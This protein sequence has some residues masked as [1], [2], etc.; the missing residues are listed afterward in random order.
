MNKR[1][2]SI[3]CCVALLF[4]CVAGLGMF[5][6]ADDTY[7]TGATVTTLNSYADADKL[8]TEESLLSADNI[9]AGGSGFNG[10][11]QANLFDGGFQ[12]VNQEVHHVKLAEGATADEYDIN[13]WDANKWGVLTDVEDTRAVLYTKEATTTTSLG[14]A[15]IGFDLGK[16]MTVDKFA[17]GSNAESANNST[18]QAIFAVDS[19][20]DGVVQNFT[21]TTRLH[22]I[23]VYFSNDADTLYDDA[24]KKVAIDYLGGNIAASMANTPLAGIYALDEVVDAQYMGFRFYVAGDGDNNK[25][26]WNGNS[27]AWGWWSQVRLSELAAYGQPATVP[28]T[29]TETAISD[30]DTFN[31]S[32]IQGSKNVLANAAVST[33]LSTSSA[34]PE[35]LTDGVVANITADYDDKSNCTVY[36]SGSSEDTAYGYFTYDFG[37]DYELTSFMLAGSGVS[38]YGTEGFDLYFGKAYGDLTALDKPRYSHE[39]NVT[40]ALKVDFDE[41]VTTQYVT[42]KVYTKKNASSYQ[43]W[44]SE[45]AATGKRVAD[46]ITVTREAVTD[47]A[48]IPG[49]SLIAGKI[50]TTA[51]GDACSYSEKHPEQ[52][53]DGYMQGLN[54]DIHMHLTQ[55]EL[56][57]DYQGKT[58]YSFIAPQSMVEAQGLDTT[59][60][61][62]LKPNNGRWQAS[63][64]SD[65]RAV[66]HSTTAKPVYDL[67]E[68]AF[69]EQILLASST[70]PGTVTNQAGFTIGEAY[71]A[72]R[73]PVMTEQQA[74][75]FKTYAM[76]QRLLW[77]AKV[78]IGST[79]DVFNE[80]ELVFEYDLSANPA[81]ALRNLW[82]LSKAVK[83]RYIGFDFTDC[84][85][86]EGNN[87]VRVS[88]IGVY[89]SKGTAATVVNN[90]NAG[91]V[92]QPA[93]NL[94][95][96]SSITTTL[97]DMGKAQLFDGKLGVSSDG[98][99]M[100]CPSAGSNHGEFWITYDLG[101]KYT[102]DS[103]FIA[104]AM[105][106]SWGGTGLGVYGMDI[107]LSDKSHTT[108]KADPTAYTPVYSTD[109]YITEG[110]LVQFANA[111]ASRYV[112]VR[113]YGHPSDGGNKGQIWLSETGATGTPVSATKTETVK[114]VC[115]GDSITH[116]ST[117]PY[118]GVAGQEWNTVQEPNNYPVQLA[119]LLNA[120]D[121]K[122]NYKVINAGIG[123][124]AAIGTDQIVPDTSDKFTGSN[125][126]NTAPTTWLTEQTSKGYVQEADVVFIML[127]TNDCANA[128]GN[129]TA[130]KPYYQEFYKKVIDAFRAKN[131]NVEIYVLTSPYADASNHAANLVE[132]AQ[133]QKQ[134]AAEWGLPCIDVY[135]ATKAF[136]EENGYE[137]YIHFGDITNGLRI[138]PGEKGLGA[139][140]QAVFDAYY[141]GEE[142]AMYTMNA[143]G[144]QLRG[145]EGGVPSG[146]LAVRFGV[147]APVAG[148][149][150]DEKYNTVLDNSKITI[151]DKQYTVTGMGAVVGIKDKID[152]VNTDLVIGT[153][154]GYLKDVP[155]RYL[156]DC[157]ADT[158]T[159]TAVITNVNEANYNRDLVA[160]GYVKYM[161]GETE[162]VA[163]GPIQIS[164][165]SEV[166]S[167]VI[168]DEYTPT[169]D[170]WQGYDRMTFTVDGVECYLIAPETPAE[171]NHWLWRTEFFNIGAAAMNTD[172]ELL[173]KGWYVAYCR[174]SNKYGNPASIATMKAFYDVAVPMANLSRKAVLLGASRGGL[175]ASNYAATYPTTVAGMYLDAP[176]QDICSWPGGSVLG[177]GYTG[178]GG[179][180][181]WNQAKQCY[182]WSSNEAALADRTASPIWKYDVLTE[183]KI[184]V[185]LV[186][187]TTDTVV[188]FAEN[189]Q[190]LVDA[191]AAAGLSDLVK[192]QS[193]ERGHVHG[194]DG[195]ASAYIIANMG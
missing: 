129:W 153:Q 162:R 172:I 27:A 189:G 181:E 97:W 6:Q 79:M 191:Y 93:D 167:G 16:V 73:H 169:Y 3:V 131:P 195:E 56:T 120:A 36:A 182:G 40:Y 4:G 31:T 110:L 128:Y 25:T 17:V 173:E 139:I 117:F 21:D 51:K 81:D 54:Q 130:R 14:Y 94:L 160:R 13:G 103:F 149:S 99:T 39:G 84:I 77:T 114:I 58:Y 127:G 89:G 143:E 8:P 18:G 46:K 70:E 190:K 38:Q 53:T 138:H 140:A 7:V 96:G 151:G 118:A 37:E 1:L 72:S 148:V 108:I 112:V 192:T 80:G 116:G 41:P 42:V 185:L 30:L 83:G 154:Q 43:T 32:G 86:Q 44:L 92:P 134:M 107:F 55:T 152:N 50:P 164:S 48:Q 45:I 71:D 156:Y 65:T 175:Y 124:S 64:V 194:W 59:Q 177:N 126:G 68:E 85:L 34:H 113:G 166:L 137:E 133:M 20:Y 132:L 176:V 135:S 26:T 111:P 22:M 163:Y 100:V 75:T 157:T 183:N 146:D 147:T 159:F 5:A 82:T 161:D 125:A 168:M 170:T 9:L 165:A 174:V 60:T 24:N 145:Y 109:E 184:P 144:A 121:K 158:A 95:K 179:A 49:E 186:Y 105:D 11:K 15:Q 188:P 122:V 29:G 2:L 52:L 98:T 88:E 47:E 119:E 91:L 193:F 10:G 63:T 155:A 23:D 115:V 101:E 150:C 102:L 35:W 66:F 123:G 69:I 62:Y 28:V 61:W 74:Q 178:T 76:D 87:L 180:S 136:A 78:Y 90:D 33:S 104:G 141:L 171:G 106:T 19:G 142:N 12:G 187:G 67:G 57:A